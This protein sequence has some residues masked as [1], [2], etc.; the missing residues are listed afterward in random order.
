[1]YLDKHGDKPKLRCDDCNKDFDSTRKLKKH[2]HGVHMKDKMCPHCGKG[3]TGRGLVVHI[4]K[5]NFGLKKIE[6]VLFILIFSQYA[7][8]NNTR[9]IKLLLFFL[10]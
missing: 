8:S 7:G 3:F 4:G 1:M 10:L 6:M 9:I 2:L 5:E